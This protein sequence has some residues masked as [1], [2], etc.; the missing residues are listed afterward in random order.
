MYGHDQFCDTII[1]GY[2]YVLIDGLLD[3]FIKNNYL[4]QKLKLCKDTKK[5]LNPDEYAIKII[6]R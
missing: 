6:K 1:E 3:K 2:G 5:Y 4:C